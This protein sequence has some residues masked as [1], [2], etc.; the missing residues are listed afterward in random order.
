MRIIVPHRKSRKVCVAA[1][2]SRRPR[3][4]RSRRICPARR[5]ARLLPHPLNQPKQRFR[6]R[7]VHFRADRAKR[8]PKRHRG[9]VF[10]RERDDELAQRLIGDPEVIFE[11]LRDF[12]HERELREFGERRHRDAERALREAR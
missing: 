1:R 2:P 8:L 4:S 3:A 5:P 7:I 10:F 9:V 6:E 12:V 11:L